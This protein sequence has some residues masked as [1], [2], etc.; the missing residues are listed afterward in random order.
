M[1]ADISATT[2]A[3]ALG[4][5]ILSKYCIFRAF[6]FIVGIGLVGGARLAFSKYCPD[7]FPLPC[8]VGRKWKKIYNIIH[9]IEP[10]HISDQ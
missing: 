7:Y 6:Y 10:L 2:S 3:Y 8:I 5:M 4:I 9:H 1:S